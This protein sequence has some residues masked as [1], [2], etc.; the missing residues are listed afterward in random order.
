LPKPYI[1]WGKGEAVGFRV[2]G[3]FAL[4]ANIRGDEHRRK[5]LAWG[6][7]SFI[8]LIVYLRWAGHVAQAALAP[9]AHAI[10]LCDM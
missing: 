3:G 7:V 2:A 1:V 8:A 9:G 4:I 5:R 6:L 10:L